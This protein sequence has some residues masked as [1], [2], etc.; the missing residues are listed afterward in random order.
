MPTI[1]NIRFHAQDGDVHCGPAAA[2]MALAAAGHD[3]T[4]ELQKDYLTISKTRPCATDAGTWR[5]TPGG[6]IELIRGMPDAVGGDRLGVACLRGEP[7]MTA[8][9]CD[10]IEAA[11]AAPDSHWPPITPLYRRAH[12]TIIT[13]F[14]GDN[15]E[16]AGFVVADPGR[17]ASLRD[18]NFVHS[19]T[20]RCGTGLQGNAAGREQDFGTPYHI[21]CACEWQ[22][23]AMVGIT[24]GTG[25]LRADP[26]LAIVSQP[27]VLPDACPVAQPPAPA[28]RW[29]CAPC[30]QP[31][32]HTSPAAL[33][34]VALDQLH[35]FPFAPAGAAS[36]DQVWH[37][38]IAATTPGQPIPI[39][40]VSGSS[41]LYYLLPFI[42]GDR[43]P[44]LLTFDGATGDLLELWAAPEGR[45]LTH[46]E[47]VGLDRLA[48]RAEFP[49]REEPRIA[50]PV[51]PLTADARR[52]GLVWAPV[53]EAPSPWL[54]FIATRRRVLDT[55]DDDGPVYVRID[56]V[57]F[58]ELTPVDG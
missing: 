44:L 21:I 42:A 52:D 23:R 58:Y 14:R 20:D 30:R 36:E 18:H 27:T 11:G 54:P 10:R 57:A 45:T 1:P 15:G 16:V 8:F 47:I 5:S 9:L 38:A 7:E 25:P 33:T 32:A 28:A 46:P 56:G 37:D 41:F 26:F 40:D 53:A 2:M 22:A 51:E 12:W 39:R 34:A 31:A 48:D 4:G 50:V 24:G 19:P 6:L 17:F 55:G 29:R 35:A 13:G 43:V 3:I 49:L